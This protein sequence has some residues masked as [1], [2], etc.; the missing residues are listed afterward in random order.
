[1]KQ[2][3]S[4]AKSINMVLLVTSKRVAENIIT[5]DQAKA[6]MKKRL[7]GVK[8]IHGFQNFMEMAPFIIDKARATKHLPLTVKK[9]GRIYV[10]LL[11][12]LLEEYY[13]GLP[14]KHIRDV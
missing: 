1:M 14:K 4:C 6:E 9:E 2:L 11:V 13:N 3:Q 10:K 5:E 8:R 7:D 12:E